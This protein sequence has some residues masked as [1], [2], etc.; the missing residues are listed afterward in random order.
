MKAEVENC[1]FSTLREDRELGRKAF[2]AAPAG[3][4]GIPG[5]LLVS[6]EVEKKVGRQLLSAEYLFKTF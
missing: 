1:D 4:S 3:E 5:S 6:R 2:P